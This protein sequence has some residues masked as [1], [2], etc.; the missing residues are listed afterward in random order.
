VTY[1]RGACDATIAHTTAYQLVI[2]EVVDGV[3]GHAHVLLVHV[4]EVGLPRVLVYR[5]QIAPFSGDLKSMGVVA[6]RVLL[7]LLMIM[8][9]VDI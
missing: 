3:H 7:L 1:L 4:V 8:P 2:H 6:K 5:V 9:E